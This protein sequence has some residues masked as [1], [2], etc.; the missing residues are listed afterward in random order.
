M[1]PFPIPATTAGGNASTS[2][3][4]PT[5][6]AVVG[7]TAAAITSCMRNVSVHRDS[8]PN[9]SN[10]KICLPCATSAA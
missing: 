7:S 10:R 5:D 6:K 4:R 3:F 9:V 2:T 8:S 1:L